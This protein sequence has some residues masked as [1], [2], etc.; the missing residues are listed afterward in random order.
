MAFTI[1]IATQTYT[2]PSGGGIAFD[3]GN[4]AGGSSSDSSGCSGPGGTYTVTST[5]KWDNFPTTLQG[6]SPND[7]QF[8]QGAFDWNATGHSDVSVPIDGSASG[9]SSAT[10]DIIGGSVGSGGFFRNCSSSANGPGPVSDNDSYTDGA[11]VTATFT[12]N[13]LTSITGA[14]CTAS[15]VIS[16]DSG[17]G[18]S[19]GISSADVS[20]TITSPRI[21]VTLTDRRCIAC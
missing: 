21:N 10:A 5:A 3:S 7:I 16:G 18:G 17:G 19:S 12:P 9:S 15:T 2:S 20:I 14:R 1:A 13:N 6:M 8:L 4:A 11:T